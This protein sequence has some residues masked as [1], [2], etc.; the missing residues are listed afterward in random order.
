MRPA[1]L[2]TV[3]WLQWRILVNQMKKQSLLSRVFGLIA[4][5]LVALASLSTTVG[6]LGASGWFLPVEVPWWLVY[7]WD[8]MAAGFVIFTLGAL[9]SDLQQSELLSLEKFLHLPVSPRGVLLLNYLASLLNLTLLIYVPP[10]FA[11]A[12]M[13]ALR[14]GGWMWMAPL[15]LAAFLF[16][17]TAL[18]WRF[19]SWIGGLMS[20]PLRRRQLIAYGSGLVIV[21]A[22]APGVIDSLVNRAEN[23]GERK[24]DYSDQVSELQ[25]QAAEQVISQ[26]ELATKLKE[27]REKRDAA[28]KRKLDWMAEK[29]QLANKV[30][31]IGW[32]PQGVDAASRQSGWEVLLCFAGMTT[33]GSWS[34]WGAWQSSIRQHRGDFGKRRPQLR[35]PESPVLA[36]GFAASQPGPDAVQGWQPAVT[37][38]SSA[39]GADRK[40]W[41]ERGFPWLSPHQAAVAWNSLRSLARA[42]EA[43]LALVWP[44][45]VLVMLL[46]GVMSGQKWQIAPEWRALA[47]VG[48]CFF[49]M[50]GVNSLLQNQFGFDRDGFRCFLLAPLA[51]DDLLIGKNAAIMPFA[52]SMGLLGLTFTQIFLPM[53]LTHF[54]ANLFQLGTLVLVGCMVSNLLSIYTPLGMKPGSMQPVNLNLGVV[55]LQLLLFLLAPLLMVPALLPLVLEWWLSATPGWSEVPFFLAGSMVAFLAVALLYRPVCRWQGTVL[56]QRRIRILEAVTHGG[57]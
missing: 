53:P 43:K 15:L 29:V 24:K 42:P 52:A 19:R 18:A 14:Y 50:M 46:G 22:L 17:V 32:L 7:V 27:L 57:S 4:L 1:H 55:V 12:V 21:I 44:I 34:L 9:F 48:I 6:V 40:N 31:P 47:G 10:V 33:I 8:G 25:E 41:L 13:M 23:G 35:K 5:V 2:M 39:V 54:I 49:V 37:T 51:E 3:V 11:F 20:D 38:L 56:Y 36:G 45:L 16:M 28:R 30:L 26:E